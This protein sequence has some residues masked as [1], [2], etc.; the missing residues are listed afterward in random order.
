MTP[1]SCMPFFLSQIILPYPMRKITFYFFSFL[2]L[3]LF[4]SGQTVPLI[5]F[6]TD[7][8]PDYDD[9]GAL[10]VLHALEARGECKILA[11]LS[12]NGHP[13]AAP[14]IELINRYF[15]RSELPV[16]NPPGNAPAFTAENGWNDSLIAKFSPGEWPGKPYP[17]AVGL[18]RK[19]LSEAE[20]NS[21]TVV[22]VGFTTNLAALLDTGSDR[23]SELSGKELIRKKIRKYVAMAGAF[24]QGKEFNVF[25][26]AG[27]SYKV[28]RE[29]PGTILFSGWEIGDPI[30]TGKKT[31]EM[32]A[33][34]S[35]VQWA[36]EYNLKTFA[37]KEVDGRPSWDHTAVLCA[38]RDP[39]DYFY[40]NGP[41][42][43]TIEE[44]GY[45]SWDPD[46][47]SGH[48]FISHKYPYAHISDILE[49]LMMYVP[50]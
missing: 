11:T 33:D 30:L 2:L 26:D 46:T 16:G 43:F 4:S 21:I 38:V 9:V 50:R 44:D 23:Y 18:Y 32:K 8:G 6:D 48:Y 10:A 13:K 28:F 27:S 7:M 19:I 31:A 1:G 15:G 49:E 24:P 37:G 42:K 20:D 14:V 5:I 40:V 36:Y 45:N 47:D 3:P 35:P 12:S 17:D 22:T 39:Q 29:W 41:G 34:N 25:T